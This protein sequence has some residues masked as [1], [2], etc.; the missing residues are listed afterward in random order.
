MG[1]CKACGGFRWDDESSFG[2]ETC[3]HDRIILNQMAEVIQPISMAERKSRH[4]DQNAYLVRYG[5][6]EELA[7]DAPLSETTLL[8]QRDLR[9]A[10]RQAAGIR[11]KR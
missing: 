9:Q 7:H 11:E 5:K 4:S 8:L 2:C 3:A 10:E 1:F 6:P